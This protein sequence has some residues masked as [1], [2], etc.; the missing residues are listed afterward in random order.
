[1]SKHTALHDWHVA[2]QAKMVTFAGY[3][4]PVS[5]PLG[6]MQ[7]HLHTR[8]KAGLFDVSHMGQI[9]LTPQSASFEQMLSTLET[10]F[11]CQLSDL[12]VGRQVYSLLLN[13][14]GGVVDDL[15]IVRRDYD[16]LLIVNAACKAKDI[17]FL[18]AHLP[19]SVLMTEL[20]DH[21]LLA[22]QGPQAASVLA[23]LGA[24]IS[25]MV[26]LDGAWVEI[27]GMRCYATR[28]GYT[29]E[30]GFE[31]SMPNNI[32]VKLAECLAAH[33]AVQPVGLGARDSLRL[34]A[35]L[36]LYGHELSESISPI[37]AGLNWAI[38]K[39]R[40]EGAANAGGFIGAETVLAQLQKGV[41]K[42]RV[43]LIAD[44]R[45]PVR[46]GAPLYLSEQA[47]INDQASIGEV[48]SGGFSPSLQQPIAMAYVDA[49]YA[50]PG[51]CV[52][53]KVRK[54][55]IPMRVATAPFVAHNYHR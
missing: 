34:E 26:F 33:D 11:P 49:D 22:L 20:D 24:D 37:Q 19:D 43:A 17:A 1:M 31:L 2:Q 30:D 9:S 29:G 28:S 50:A 16:V 12:A 23:D 18:A 42:V 7:E 6:V 27:Q 52:F 25:S 3:Q 4:M 40:R 41:D 10:I 54:K 51:A 15:M 13:D 53:A 5:Y 39:Q 44:G 32:A 46:E 48:V 47:G 38:A 35:G 45:A 14:H 21:A 55:L 8:A 36:C